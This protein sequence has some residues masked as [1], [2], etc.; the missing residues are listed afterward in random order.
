MTTTLSF[1]EFLSPW[2][3]RNGFKRLELES[4]ARTVS[5]LKKYKLRKLVKKPVQDIDGIVL[6]AIWPTFRSV[7]LLRRNDSFA[8]VQM[9]RGKID[10]FAPEID[11]NDPS[12]SATVTERVFYRTFSFRTDQGE[13]VF[14]DF[15]GRL[16]GPQKASPDM[17]RE[18]GFSAFDR[19]VAILNDES[20]RK[21]LILDLSKRRFKYS[22]WVQ[23]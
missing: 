9:S 22:R 21:K 7:C 14:R 6:K 19:L 4:D 1:V 13:L 23:G 11:L 5:T 12:F 20:D 2:Q 18:L 16:I 15:A 10:P 17:F 3:G 8:F